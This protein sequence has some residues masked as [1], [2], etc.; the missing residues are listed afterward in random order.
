MERRDPL[1]GQLI[2]GRY[3][4][5][6]V[7][8]EGA[9]GIVYRAV[10]SS[11]D[12][13]VAIKVLRP[14]ISRSELILARFKQE[15]QMASR[16]GNQH[17]VDISDFG[18]LRDGS[19]YFAMEFLRG[20]PLASALTEERFTFERTV[21][22][23]KQLCSALGAAHAAGIVHRDLKPD[24][25]QLTQRGD[26]DDF[27][28]VL[29]FGIAKV[30]GASRVLT[31][32]GQ[33][34]GT[35]HYM[36]PEQ[37]AG[38][39][40]D[41]RTD[42]YAVGVIL[43]QMATGQL[44]FDAPNV[45]GILQKQMHQQPTPPEELAPDADIPPGLSDVI[46]RCLEKD[47]DDRY[48]SMDEL[49]ADLEAVE[50]GSFG[51]HDAAGAHQLELREGGNLEATDFEV[52][53]KR[54]WPWLCALVALLAIYFGVQLEAW[55]PQ[56]QSSEL[57]LEP[58][59][60][61]PRQHEPIAAAPQAT[62]ATPVTITETE[63]AAAG[64]D[65]T[66]VAAPAPAASTEVPEASA[67]SPPPEVVPDRPASK[68]FVHIDSDPPGAQVYK[69]D[70]RIGLTPISIEKPEPAEIAEITLR[71]RGYEVLEIE[72]DASVDDA[73]ELSLRPRKA[74]V[75]RRPREVQPPEAPP[76]PARPAIAEQSELLDPWE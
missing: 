53:R 62:S 7:L 19:T 47:P 34:F 48:A 20:R 59:P 26:D 29:D 56:G 55:L 64:G 6:A 32:V 43:Y 70:V 38:S 1:L 8:G 16:I 42:I 12:K 28:K 3:R 51:D 31:Q 71:R 10:H 57:A 68:P 44:P 45:L 5:E 14:D 35:P 21:H 9:M 30:I 75:Q 74:R 76:E 2:D 18:E 67:E 69:D 11:I 25:V 27:V 66:G 23:G 36:S 61:S 33:V 17:I 46:L 22:V 60:Q 41:H 73:L 72:I 15:A 4:I 13:R 24:N 52:P 49:Q 65:A 50:A 58:A 39:E 63:S 54:I 37:C 40:V